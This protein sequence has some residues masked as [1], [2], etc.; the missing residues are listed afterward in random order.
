MDEGALADMTDNG[1]VTELCIIETSAAVINNRVKYTV[2]PQEY[3]GWSQKDIFFWLET[4]AGK[5][6][7]LA[8]GYDFI[9]SYVIGKKR[10][11]G[12]ER[13]GKER[14]GKER[15]GKERKGKERKGKEGK[16]RKGKERKG[17]ERKGKERKG[18][19]RKGKERKGKERK[20]KERKGKERKG[21]ERRGEER[22][23]KNKWKE[24]IKNMIVLLCK[25]LMYLTGNHYPLFFLIWLSLVRCMHFTISKHHPGKMTSSNCFLST[26]WSRPAI[27][28]VC[29]LSFQTQG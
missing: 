8:L 29:G 14:K 22:K 7:P 13:K 20:G 21:K 19:E 15:K 25:T 24:L 6:I 3:S 4:F 11:K 27:F 12:K 1:P 16:E 28:H 26:C 17:K 18:K 9:R 5:Y 23:R 2:W 10:R